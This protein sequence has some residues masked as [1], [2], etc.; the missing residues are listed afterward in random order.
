MHDMAR[1]PALMRARRT[2]DEVAIVPA[3]WARVVALARKQLNHTLRGRRRG[4]GESVVVVTACTL[5]SSVCVGTLMRHANE[6]VAQ[7]RTWP[8]ETHCAPMRH[9][10]I[11]SP[12][13]SHGLSTPHSQLSKKMRSLHI[14]RTQRTWRVCTHHAVIHAT[15]TPQRA[16]TRATRA[17]ARTHAPRRIQAQAHVGVHLRRVQLC[18]VHHRV[19]PVH[20]HVAHCARHTVR[21]ARERRVACMPRVRHAPPHDANVAASCA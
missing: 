15:T 18:A 8:R 2:Y 21:E 7:A 19:A 4:A 12:A 3:A 5:A 16:R 6:E 11:H 1:G 9:E 13:H 14:R 10:F 17:H 20:L